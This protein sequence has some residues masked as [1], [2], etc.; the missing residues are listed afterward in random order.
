M[1]LLMI[2]RKVDRSDSLAGFS[3]RWVATLATMV[4]ELQVICL[5]AGDL[6]GLPKNCFVH[7]L[8]TTRQKNR[9]SEFM[10][11]HAYARTWV[12]HVDGVFSHQN[13]EYGILIAPWCKWY[14]KKLLAWY[15]HKAVTFRLRLLNALSDR[16]V[17]ASKESLRLPSKKLIV[18]HHG[19]D[20]DFFSFRPK[21]LS[22]GAS[23]LSVSRISQT[24]NIHRMI[25]LIEELKKRGMGGVQLTIVG[26]PALERDQA[27]LQRLRTMVV[28]KGLASA[29][30]FQGPVPYGETVRLYHDADLFL[31]FSATGSIDKA[32]LEAMSCGTLV[33]VTNEAFKEILPAIDANLYASSVK[34]LADQAQR[35]LASTSRVQIAEREREYVSSHHDLSRLFHAIVSLYAHAS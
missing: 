1:K 6:S 12:P 29:I 32:V 4:D 26:S 25:E 10:R 21:P 23:L 11:F 24:K 18:L 33:L 28:E 9:W 34:D 31:N 22:G 17:T 15:T 14:R 20:T 27:Y 35:L 2:T 3:F 30:H 5:E 7:P 8:R 16:L 13:P 19:I